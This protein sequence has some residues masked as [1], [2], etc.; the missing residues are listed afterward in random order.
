MG[1]LNRIGNWFNTTGAKLYNAVR[2]G[3]STGYNFVNNVA[4][5]VGSISDGIDNALSQVKSIPVVG[6][7]ASLLQNNPL[8]QEARGL[9]KSGVGVVDQVGQLGKD[10]AKPVDNLITSTVFR[11]NP[12]IKPLN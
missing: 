5:K 6:Q 9:I 3:V 10:I 4:H 2:Q 7:A 11:D 8:Y 12:N 1:F